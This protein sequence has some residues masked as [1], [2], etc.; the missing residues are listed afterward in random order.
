VTSAAFPAA[1][2]AGVLGEPLGPLRALGV[3]LL[4]GGGGLVAASTSLALHRSARRGGERTSA[5]IA[6]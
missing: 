2:G 5:G 4:I 1:I 6:S 3:A